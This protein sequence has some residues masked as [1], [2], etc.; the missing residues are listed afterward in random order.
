MNNQLREFERASR[1]DIYGLGK[2][3]NKWEASLD[4]FAELIVQECVRYFN[5][6]YVRDFDVLWREDLSK[7]MKEHFGVEE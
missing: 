2:D 5:E 4:K 3:R 7:G 6:D 1:L